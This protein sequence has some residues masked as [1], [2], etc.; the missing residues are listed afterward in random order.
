MRHGVEELAL[1]A[2]RGQ[3]RLWFHCDMFDMPWSL[4][5]ESNT[6]SPPPPGQK[7]LSAEDEWESPTWQDQISAAALASSDLMIDWRWRSFRI[8]SND[9]WEGLSEV[10]VIT[11][12][13][14]SRA[15][16][17]PIWVT[18]LIT[19]VPPMLALHRILRERRHALEGRCKCGYD[20]R[21]TPEKCPEC[22]AMPACPGV[23]AR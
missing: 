4:H 5:W 19:S 7:V 17:F 10:D 8:V 9:I 23:P 11:Y 6:I 1:E 13:R 14:P 20:L 12:P 15:I 18:A 2:Y 22:G 3:L 21:A 16:Y